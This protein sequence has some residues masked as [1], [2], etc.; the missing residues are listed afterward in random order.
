MPSPQ[1]ANTSF[2]GSAARI[3]QEAV[4]EDAS[5]QDLAKIAGGDPGF[6]LRLLALVNSPAYGGKSVKTVQQAASLLGLRGV[7]NLALS[8]VVS[9]L[10]P[11]G[12]GAQALLEVSL[13]RAVAARLVGERMGVRD[14]DSCFTTGLLLEVGIL[15]QA[16]A[17]FE[18]AARVAQAPAEERCVLEQALEWDTHP[19]SGASLGREL[20]L[21]DDMIAAIAA[22]H[23]Q[24]PPDG[25]LPR[26]GW[27]A[28]KLAAVYEGPRV[29]ASK[30][31]AIEA[32]QK[33][34]VD[35]EE[36]DGI[37]EAIR[38]GLEEAAGGFQ[39]KVGKQP[40]LDELMRDA[41]R[42]LAKMNDRYESMVRTL[43]QLV[44]EK[45]K[46]TDELKNANEALERLATTDPLTQIPNKRALTDQLTR[47]IARADREGSHLSLVVCD[48]DHFKKFNDTYGH[49]VGDDVLK[50]VAQTLQSGLRI[51]DFVGRY[52]GEEFV[53]LLP[54]TDGPGAKILAERLREALAEQVVAHP[55]GPLRVTASFGIATV[56]GP[57]CRDQATT[58]FEVAD[59][60]LYKAKE[61]GRNC[62]YVAAA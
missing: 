6:S 8:I 57:G 25:E 2:S 39:R 60:S 16:G 5:I 3:V 40:S 58:L 22:H 51:S 49:A 42:S 55:D 32:L 44:R 11:E 14:L 21:A 54:N 50:A 30:Q 19:D 28:E 7:R 17:L 27:A 29:D 47:D 26:V 37:F 10:V 36:D 52:G 31:K 45:Q 4:K 33:V 53:V 20:V 59:K 56:N 46:L 41:N 9:D 43:E 62:V 15:S 12:E 61:A 48:V 24:E 23:E 18:D 38:A 34:G 1:K 35:V 13:R